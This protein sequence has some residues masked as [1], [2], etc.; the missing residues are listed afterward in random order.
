LACLAQEFPEEAKAIV[1]DKAESPST[2]PHMES[3][4]LV[5]LGINKR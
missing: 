3:F 4:A 1:L 2:L 5:H